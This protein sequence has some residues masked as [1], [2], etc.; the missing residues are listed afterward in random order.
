MHASPRTSTFLGASL[1]LLASASY[2]TMG[3]FVKAASAGLDVWTIVFYRSVFLV[4]ALGL[5]FRWQGRS[6]RI[7]HPRLLF[8]RC[9]TGFGALVCYFFAISAIPLADAI[10]LQRTFPIWIALLSGI[11]LGER[12]PLP[13]VLWICAAFVGA[14]MIVAPGWTDVDPYALVALA[15][16]LLSSFAYLSIRALRRWEEAETIV[17]YFGIFALLAS[18]PMALVKGIAPPSEFWIYLV[19]IG[20]FATLGQIAMTH[21]YHYAH[22]AFV[23]A[24]SYGGVVVGVALGFFFF[25]EKLSGITTFGIAL[26]VLAGVALS[27][28]RSEFSGD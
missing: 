25:D 28:R 9:V 21:A 17:F 27:R 10:T 3:A 22:A 7:H 4:L 23:G 1:M 5:L 11:A 12:T 20:L 13:T 24:F 26:I 14:T 6:L 15:S 18:T 19:A 8:I 16:A 2:A